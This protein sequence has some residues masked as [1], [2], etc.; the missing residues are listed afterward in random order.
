MDDYRQGCT[1]PSISTKVTSYVAVSAKTGRAGGAIFAVVALGVTSLCV[2]YSCFG[3]E[4]VD[5]GIFCR[6]RAKQFCLGTYLF[7]LSVWY[8]VM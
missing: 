6:I 7:P 3:G 1:K 4:V 5:F 8:V 2:F